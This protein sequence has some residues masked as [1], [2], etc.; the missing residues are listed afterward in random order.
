VPQLA[1]PAA[2]GCGGR[3]GK[4]LP[5]GA[6]G[7]QQ[8]VGQLRVERKQRIGVGR[9]ERRGGGSVEGGSRSSR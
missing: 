7:G 5:R 4:H 6:A 9:P 1:G 2:A 3:T 8:L